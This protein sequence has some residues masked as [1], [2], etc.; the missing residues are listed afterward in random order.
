MTDRTVASANFNSTGDA[1]KTPLEAALFYLSRGWCP[2]PL[3][4]PNCPGNLS[5]RH[6][7]PADRSGKVP[8]VPGWTTFKE[9]P[10]HAQVVSWW[11][12]WP[13][14]NVGVICGRISGIIGVD[15]DGPEGIDEL[16]RLTGGQIPET[17]RFTTPSGGR[18]LLFRY[19]PGESIATRHMGGK[20]RPLS[21]LSDGS[22]TVMPPSVGHNGE[23]YAWTDG[24]APDW[25]SLPE[26]PV[27]VTAPAPA[28]G[29]PKGQ[30]V[31]GH[32]RP[33]L[34]DQAD[35]EVI[36][37]ARAYLKR[38]KPAVEGE[39]GDAHTYKMACKL[40]GMFGM[41]SDNALSLLMEWNTRC[42]P[43]WSEDAL[44][45]KVELAKGRHTE[46]V[47]GPAAILRSPSKGHRHRVADDQ[48][49]DQAEQ[50]PGDHPL[51]GE[52]LVG[53]PRRPLEWFDRPYVARSQV[54]ALVGKPGTGKSTYLA[55]LVGR[56]KY[57]LYFPGEEDVGRMLRP[58]IESAGARLDQVRVIPP[59]D[60]WVMPHAR[61]R[62]IGAINQ[63][64]ADLVVF[65]PVDDYLS[66]AV[67]ENAN[68]AVRGVLQAFREVAEKTG[69]AV[70]ICRHV[71]K[72][73][74]NVMPGSRA[75]YAHPRAIVE[76]LADRDTPPKRIIRLHK[77]SL[78]QN[79]PARY[80]ELPRQ[81]CDPPRFALGGEAVPEIVELVANVSDPMERRVVD[82]ACDLVRRLLADGRMEAKTVFQH[83][84]GE[85]LNERAMRRA[86]EQLGVKMIREGNG[87]E[88]RC[89]W[90]MPENNSGIPE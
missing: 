41:S 57:A 70:V 59:T 12:R 47:V 63:T 55:H 62:L 86:A 8:L 29:T 22:Q 25:G 39:G 53:V 37:R 60:V 10:S 9:L 45:R 2:I 7:H 42:V 77:D 50:L 88:H 49:G 19:P 65:D 54:T 52:L 51:P 28:R 15:V 27:W 33:E 69:A 78:G 11:G 43:P 20:T 72:D 84:E 13:D 5:T 81:G 87:K 90:E 6:K 46:T 3:C 82:R 61:E 32:C 83:A 76:L 79:P 1:P 80:F 58:R 73:P 35:A 21:I 30:T 14:A 4:P 71:G 75:W 74:T 34:P 64:G 17:V 68:V 31:G 67:D 26:A 38:C 24:L 16:L 18:R 44:R 23:R 48:A 36:R 85:R 56:S 89:Y 40:V 66:D